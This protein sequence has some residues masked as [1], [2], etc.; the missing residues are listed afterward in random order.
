[1]DA[2]LRGVIA[3]CIADTGQRLKS[4]IATLDELASMQV[5][6]KRIS[7]PAYSPD[8]PIHHITLELA[9]AV[10]Q[11]YAQAFSQLIDYAILME[12][13]GVSAE[14]Q[15]VAKYKDVV[16]D[17][18]LIFQAMLLEK[19]AAADAANAELH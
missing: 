13:P 3:A 14:L 10:S 11:A 8:Y 9:L 17:P 7:Q 2:T 16:K 18:R 12:L 4:W 5:I 1:M 15:A 6:T 19:Q